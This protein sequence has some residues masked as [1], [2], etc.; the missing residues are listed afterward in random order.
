MVVNNITK[1]LYEKEDNFQIVDFNNNS[2]IC[3][4]FFSSNAVC[5]GYNHSYECVKGRFEWQNIAKS[6]KI[7]KK[8]RRIIF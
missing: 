6:P 8:A 1:S 3:Y 4:V 5:Y 7:E 2:N